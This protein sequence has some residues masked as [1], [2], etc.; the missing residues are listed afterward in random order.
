MFFVVLKIYGRVCEYKNKKYN[1]ITPTG[2]LI[3]F[4]V[5]G[6]ASCPQNN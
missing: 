4:S 2:E 1:R 5:K 3:V 6:T